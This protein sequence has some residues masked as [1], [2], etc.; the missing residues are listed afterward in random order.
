MNYLM[1]NSSELNVVNDAVETDQKWKKRHILN[2]R[3]I[4]PKPRT[5]KI[6][7]KK[8]DLCIVQFDVFTILVMKA[9]DDIAANYF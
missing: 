1:I 9:A 3:K 7:N 4:S 2:E 5:A 6:V 8:Q